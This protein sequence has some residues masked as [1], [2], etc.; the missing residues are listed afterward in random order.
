MNE[1]VIRMD[2]VSRRFGKAVLAVDNMSLT[3]EAAN[4]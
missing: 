2:R 1:P 4:S 3:I